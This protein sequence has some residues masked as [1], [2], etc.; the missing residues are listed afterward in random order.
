[1]PN[2]IP[3]E[4]KNKME[5]E[6]RQYWDNVDK[7]DRLERDIIEESGGNDGQPRSNITSDT[8]SQKAMKIM[9]TRSILVLHERI[10]Y[11]KRTIDRL[12][13]FEREVFYMIFKDNC[14]CLY[15][16]TMKRNKQVY[17]L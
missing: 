7:L 11:V 1:M 3:K 13:P 9:S 8:T 5:K 15:C 16:E 12:K 10:L 4:L 14:D 2:K 6:L 17:I